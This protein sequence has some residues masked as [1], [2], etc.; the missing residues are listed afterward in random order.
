MTLEKENIRYFQY[1][2]DNSSNIKNDTVFIYG[3]DAD[4]VMLTLQSTLNIVK[5]CIFSE[6]T[7]HFIKSIDKTL[8]PNEL[9]V[10]DIPF[11]AEKIEKEMNTMPKENA[12][13]D[14]VFM[15]F[16]LG[17]DFIP[18]M[19]ALNIRTNGIDRLFDAYSATMAGNS[20][21]THNGK[22]NLEIV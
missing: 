1:I 9:Y 20:S 17:N 8:N 12:I 14:Y 19:P 5:K 6:R 16:M 2:R 4:L 10:V 11:F 13:S 3:L 21:L 7:P 15:S 18:H 22:I